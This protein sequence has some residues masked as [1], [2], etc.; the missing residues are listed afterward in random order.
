MSNSQQ[1][2]DNSLFDESNLEPENGFAPNENIGDYIFSNLIDENNKI[3]NNK[4]ELQKLAEAEEY[5]R[6][7]YQNRYREE[8][9]KFCEQQEQCTQQ[10]TPIRY[11]PIHLERTSIYKGTR[12]FD[13]FHGNNKNIDYKNIK[14]LSI[15]DAK[16]NTI[17]EKYNQNFNK[18]FEKKFEKNRNTKNLG[19]AKII[20]NNH[21]NDDKQTAPSTGEK[22]SF[23]FKKVNKVSEKH[24]N[25]TSWSD[26]LNMMS[27]NTNT[28]LLKRKVPE[29]L[30]I[31]NIKIK[32]NSSSKE[33]QN[34]IQ[35]PSIRIPKKQNKIPNTW[36]N[37]ATKGQY[38]G[39]KNILNRVENDGK[40]QL[41]CQNNYR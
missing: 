24:T 23:S 36:K 39:T 27:K 9:D 5:M 33:H 14:D 32:K 13:Y 2:I 22:T 11:T 15:F 20:T 26:L 19:Q 12:D 34:I 28:K 29:A 40:Y 8:C 7:T 21:I 1:V 41:F 35:N 10:Y 37:I 6:E 3:V 25:K 31:N 16:N 38:N 30:R 18:A 4:S 17:R